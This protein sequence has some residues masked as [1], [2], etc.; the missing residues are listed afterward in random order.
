MERF[1]RDLRACG[2]LCEGTG[3][4]RSLRGVVVESRETWGFDPLSPLLLLQCVSRLLYHP[5]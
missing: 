4:R 5:V 1:K 3:R 2:Y